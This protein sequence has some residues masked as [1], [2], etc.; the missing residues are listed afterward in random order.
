MQKLFPPPMYEMPNN[1]FFEI[2]GVLTFFTA[3]VAGYFAYQLIKNWQQIH[4]RKW[5]EV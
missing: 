4:R 3:V 5:L 2:T 1:L